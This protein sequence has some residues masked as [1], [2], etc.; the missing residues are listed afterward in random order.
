MLRVDFNE[1]F[2]LF[3]LGLGAGWY[4]PIKLYIINIDGLIF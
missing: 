2:I 4:N 3:P 1:V